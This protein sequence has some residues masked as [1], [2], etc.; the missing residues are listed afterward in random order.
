LEDTD[1]KG[2][3]SKNN[4]KH[5]KSSSSKVS[6]SEEDKPSNGKGSIKNGSASDK[7]SVPKKK[8][9]FD[10]VSSQVPKRLNDI[11]DAPPS[12]DGLLKKKTATLQ[13]NDKPAAFGKKD[14]VP[15]EQRRMMEIEREKAIKRY[16]ELKEQR[17]RG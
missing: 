17:S 4:E 14:V 5:G 9:E 7:L 3:T 15:P 13:K 8:T 16:R 10:A 6:E 2:S 1:T 12:L 11:V